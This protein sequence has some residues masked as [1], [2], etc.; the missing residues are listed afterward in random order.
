M[1]IDLRS[2]S[3]SIRS[4]SDFNLI[5]IRLKECGSLFMCIELENLS[6]HRNLHLNDVFPK[7][8]TDIWVMFLVTKHN[9]NA[10]FHQFD[11]QRHRYKRSFRFNH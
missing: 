10:L 7:T 5:L 8:M 9:G 1:E 3:L 11:Q 4:V 2:K 6:L